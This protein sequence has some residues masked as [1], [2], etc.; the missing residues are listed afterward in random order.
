[1]PLSR[2]AIVG[3]SNRSGEQLAA[4][5]HLASPTLRSAGGGG[6]LD[7][8]SIASALKTI[9]GEGSDETALFRRSFLRLISVTEVEETRQVN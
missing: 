2:A 8:G 6:R 9:C 4:G 3:L 1:V 7:G 5:V